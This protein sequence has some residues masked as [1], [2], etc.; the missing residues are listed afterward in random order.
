MIFFKISIILGQCNVYLFILSFIILII[1]MIFSIEGLYGYYWDLHYHA[2]IL[3]KEKYSASEF[4]H[5]SNY[6]SAKKYYDEKLYDKSI[7]DISKALKYSSK[8]TYDKIAED[9]LLRG[10]AYLLNKQF[11]Y[12]L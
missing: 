7:S 3:W 12:L 5:N 8:E 9:Y 1:L 10:K 4:L 2:D 11:I 6:K